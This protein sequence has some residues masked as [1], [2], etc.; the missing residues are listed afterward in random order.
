MTVPDDICLKVQLNTRMLAGQGDAKTNFNKLMLAM[1]IALDEDRYH[2]A[3]Q[4]INATGA[5]NTCGFSHQGLTAYD[6]WTSH[7]SFLLSPFC[8]SF[9]LFLSAS[10]FCFSSL[11]L[12]SAS[13]SYFFL[14]CFSFL[15]IL[16]A[17]EHLGS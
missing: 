2:F 16:P 14:V 4:L 6:H 8:F 13:P 5:T 7:V 1:F 11:L 3:Y 9:L 10:P 12:I 17:S 15:L